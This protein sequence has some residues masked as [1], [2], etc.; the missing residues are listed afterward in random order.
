MSQLFK[1]HPTHPQPRLMSQA[2]AVVMAGGVIVYP[3]DSSYALGWRLGEKDAMDRVRR[4]RGLGKDHFSSLICRDLS[5]LATYARVDNSAFRLI[6]AHTP[7]PYTFLLRATRDVPRRMQH[8]KRKTVGLRV[9]DNVIVRAL[10]D[11]LGEPIMSSTLLL[12][13]DDFPMSEPED[14]LERVGRHCDAVI[15]G[16]VGGT[17]YTTV[18]DLSGDAPQLVRL[19]LGDVTA[20][21]VAGSA[22]R[23]TP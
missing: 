1:A 9:P 17:D 3:T 6:R 10:L 13:G 5:E 15:D 21:D 12:P 22:S 19:G 4:L 11:E 18:V 7:G 16:G 14:I 20:F 23:G 2:A 8:P